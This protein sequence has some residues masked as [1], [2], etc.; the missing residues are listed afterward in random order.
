MATLIVFG[1]VI[2]IFALG[3]LAFRYGGSGDFRGKKK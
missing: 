1:V 3:L 2:L